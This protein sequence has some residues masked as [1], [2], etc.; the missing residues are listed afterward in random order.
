MNAFQ[1]FGIEHLSP[2]SLNEFASAQALFVLRRLLK[3]NTGTVGAAAHRGTAVETG[4]AAGLADPKANL[5]DCVKV[6]LDQ[7]RLLTSMSTDSRKEKEEMSIAGF[8]EEGLKALRPLGVPTSTQGLCSMTVEGL[9]VPIIGYYDFCFPGGVLVDLKTT[10]ALP[11]SIS[12]AHAQQVALYASVLG[13]DT[14]PCLAY[15]S[16]KRSSLLALENVLEHVKALQNKALTVQ[17]FLNLSDDPME[18]AKLCVPD[19]DSFYY[20]SPEARAAAFE[21]Y[22]I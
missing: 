4:V 8:V 19:V 17:R 5:T 18:L 16:S 13:S 3:K 12:N 2:S 6:A 7:F 15:V 9:D 10:H 11:S 21:V 1:K 14:K 20:S 22:G